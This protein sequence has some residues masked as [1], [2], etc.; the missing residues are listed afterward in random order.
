MSLTFEHDD[1]TLTVDELTNGRRLLTVVPRRDNIYVL[2]NT[3]ETAYP[4]DLVQTIFEAYGP[5]STCHAIVR[6]KD[7]SYVQRLLTNDL[8][9]LFQTGG[10]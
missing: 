8:F 9:C 7:P 5:R 3:W 4:L 6:E 10:L 1:G 2:T